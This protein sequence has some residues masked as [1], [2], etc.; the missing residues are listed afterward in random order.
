MTFYWLNPHLVLVCHVQGRAK[1]DL[2][3]GVAQPADGEGG[4]RVRT[5]QIITSPPV[6]E[7]VPIHL[8]WKCVCHPA[9]LKEVLGEK[10]VSNSVYKGPTPFH[11]LYILYI[12][13]FPGT[14]AMW[15]LWGL[16]W[17]TRAPTPPWCSTRCPSSSSN[18]STSTTW[19]SSVTIGQAHRG[20]T[21]HC[22]AS[23]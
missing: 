3:A 9:L 11:L 6:F 2:H 7:M 20:C 22:V 21:Q 14:S 23:L 19:N 4:G 16:T 5:S 10:H 15:M 8:D 12:I 18:L 1:C 13:Y 17:W